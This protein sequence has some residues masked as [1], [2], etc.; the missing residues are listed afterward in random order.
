MNDW[1]TFDDVEKEFRYI[2]N[3]KRLAEP[4]GLL[5]FGEI[6]IDLVYSGI[7]EYQ[8]VQGLGEKPTKIMIAFLLAMGYVAWTQPHREKQQVIPRVNFD[9]ATRHFARGDTQR[10]YADYNLGFNNSAVPHADHQYLDQRMVGKLNESYSGQ[11][12]FD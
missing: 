8:F 3:W 5:V 9:G 2:T 10:G 4:F 6:G 7:Q 11:G 1:E 12:F